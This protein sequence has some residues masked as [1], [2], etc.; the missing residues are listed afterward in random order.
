MH[1]L[2][3]RESQSFSLGSHCCVDAM[4]FW[5]DCPQKLRFSQ[6]LL[7]PGLDLGMGSK[8]AGDVIL[9]TLVTCR[10]GSLRFSGR[11]M[12]IYQ[13]CNGSEWE[14]NQKSPICPKHVWAH[15]P[16]WYDHVCKVSQTWLQGPVWSDSVQVSH[17]GQVFSFQLDE[18]R[19][20]SSGAQTVDLTA[21]LRK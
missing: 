8:W 17:C 15:P 19:L 12:S 6:I 1:C 16:T 9:D 3:S 18:L 5:T 11:K 14:K 7:K 13:R 20:S 21:K 10:A 2:Q 4:S